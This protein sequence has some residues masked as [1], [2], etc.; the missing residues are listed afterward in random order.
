MFIEIL[1][2]IEEVWSDVGSMI[3]TIS[4]TNKKYLQYNWKK[5]TLSYSLSPT[6]PFI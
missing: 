3:L 1:L 2:V 5:K 4:S 6:P